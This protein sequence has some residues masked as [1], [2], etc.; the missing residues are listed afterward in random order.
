ML[1]DVDP[2]KWNQ[3]SGGLQGVLVGSTGYDELVV[4]LIEAQPAPAG[5]LNA[6]GNGGDS[7]L[8][9]LESCKFINQFIITNTSN[10]SR[11]IIKLSN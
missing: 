7:G 1:P 11:V 3:A 6:N 8:E 10:M 2:E 9:A 5:A 4:G